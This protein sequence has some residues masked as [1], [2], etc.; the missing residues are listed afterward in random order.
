M[1]YCLILFSERCSPDQCDE[2]L[3]FQIKY[4]R[5]IEIAYG[6][7]LFSLEDPVVP[8]QEGMWIPNHLL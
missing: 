4:S 3:R 7:L 1:H 8:S 2:P 6:F 5:S